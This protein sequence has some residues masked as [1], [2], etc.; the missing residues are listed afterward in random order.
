MDD[1]RRGGARNDA[2][3][4][5]VV[6]PFFDNAAHVGDCAASLLRQEGVAASVEIIF[7]DNGSEDGSA[8]IVADYDGITLIREPKPGAYAARNA[9][10]RVARGQIIAF[11]DA[12]CAVAPDWLRS[13]LDGMQND[14]TGILVGHVRYPDDASRALRMLG[15]YEN[16]KV[17]YVLSRCPPEYH[18]GYTN[19]MAVRASVF[20]EIGLFEEWKRA[21]DSELVHRM[22]ARRPDLQIAYCP[23]MQV[24]HLEFTT[25][26]SRA[27]R[28]SLYTSTNSKI[29]TFKELG[30]ARRFGVLMHLLAQSV[31]V[32]AGGRKA[33]ER[34]A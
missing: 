7:V 24:T 22:A 34:S 15:A 3:A 27:R 25:F 5:S 12:D 1:A 26:R 11:T 33:A 16:A 32:G 21:G 10:I 4:V 9:G 2:P 14:E 19:N 6:V 23:S 17:D 8:E 20:A 29:S 31:G 13:I 30:A 18:F 28:L